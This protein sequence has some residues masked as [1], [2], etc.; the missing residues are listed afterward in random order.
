MSNQ[1]QPLRVSPQW[2]LIPAGEES[3]ILL[4]EQQAFS[5]ILQEFEYDFMTMQAQ[6]DLL[7]TL[8]AGNEIYRSGNYT[9]SSNGRVKNYVSTEVSEKTGLPYC[10]VS[11]STGAGI[12]QNQTPK[13]LKMPLKISPNTVIYANIKNQSAYFSHAIEINFAGLLVQEEIQ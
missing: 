4:M 2:R 11:S 13:T 8:I 12:M 10:S 1:I 5:F 3:K 6:Q 9:I 7:V